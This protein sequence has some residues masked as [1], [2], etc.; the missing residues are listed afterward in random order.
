DSITAVLLHHRGDAIASKPAPTGIALFLLD[1][2]TRRSPG[3]FFF[4]SGSPLT[5]VATWR[6]IHDT[7]DCRG[8]TV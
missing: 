3:A 7:T 2:E 1:Y 5:R 8:G 4:A 6:L